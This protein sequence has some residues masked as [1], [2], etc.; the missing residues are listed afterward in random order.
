MNVIGCGCILT[1]LMTVDTSENFEASNSN[2]TSSGG[3]Y[4]C[5]LE[6]FNATSVNMVNSSKNYSTLV[7]I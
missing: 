2:S 7:K 3:L 6:I 5:N 4:L 1:E